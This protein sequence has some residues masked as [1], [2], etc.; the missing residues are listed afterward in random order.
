M[1][2]SKVRL[3]VIGMGIMGC[4]YARMITSGQIKGAELAAVTRVRPEKMEEFS[5]VFEQKVPI[6]ASA[7]ALFE[8]VEQKQLDVDAVLVVTPHLAHE[9]QVTRALQLG[10]HALCDKPAGAYS[11][12]ARNMREEAEK[13]D[14]LVFGMVFNQRMNPIFQKMKEIVASGRYGRMIR[15]NWVMTDWYRPDAYY[16]SGSWRGTW[17]GEGGGILLNQCPHNLDLLQWI[18]GMPVSVQAFCKEGKYHDIAVE[19]EVTAYMEFTDGATG[20]IYS[21]TGEASGMNRLEISMEDALLVYENNEL[22]VR[23]L[24]VHESEYRKTATDFFAQPKGTWKVIDCE[25]SD[26][27]HAGVLQNFVDAILEKEELFIPGA[28]GGKSLILSNAMYLSSW[29]KR[30]VKIPQNAEEEYAFEKDFEA[31]FAVKA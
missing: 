6:F 3:A 19:D 18:C 12:Q 4:K 5:D 11:R 15:M 8:A 24:A 10:L 22:K 1:K 17:D 25:G 2:E 21:T 26:P 28:E 20:V 23:E 27:A 7:D 14:N 16:A 13:H 9:E 31:E 29:Q 30:M